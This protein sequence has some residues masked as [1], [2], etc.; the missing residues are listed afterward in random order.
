MKKLFLSILVFNCL[1]NYA[2]NID[3]KEDDYERIY[4]E[5]GQI[6]PMGDFKKQFD[7]SLHY[8]FWFRTKI[9]HYNFMDIGI[10]FYIP[11]NAQPI[12]I[13]KKGELHSFD[14]TDFT[15]S[16]GGRLS[17]VFRF[18]DNVNVEW[19]SGFGV[20]FLTYNTPNTLILTEEEKEDKEDNV[21]FMPYLSQGLR[22]NYKNVG[23]QA[24]MHL[25][26]TFSN[27]KPKENIGNFYLTFGIVYRQ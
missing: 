8:G 11:K 14:S 21:I 4:V 10:N 12:N 1:Y 20:K 13:F 2:Q 19:I 17:K 5:F 26:E 22:W 3:N 6:I 18:S 7:N 9:K 15:F 24:N 23:L 25:G 27:L 16:I